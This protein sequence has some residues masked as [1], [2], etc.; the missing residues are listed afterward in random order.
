M[1]VP[2]RSVRMID[3]QSDD[4]DDAIKRYLPELL[5][6]VVWQIAIDRNKDRRSMIDDGFNQ[7]R[8]D[9]LQRRSPI[10]YA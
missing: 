3:Q 4:D 2:S 9:A 10:T 1:E 7:A 6:A 5:L 8:C